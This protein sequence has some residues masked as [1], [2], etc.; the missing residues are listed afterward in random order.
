MLIYGA[1]DGGVMVLRE[2]L[3]QP[4]ARPRAVAFLDD[5]RSKHRTLIQRLPVIGGLD[6]L[7]RA[8]TRPARP[9]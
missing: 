8:V 9:R 4:R 6:A 7:A 1:G 2:L 5:D 3:Q